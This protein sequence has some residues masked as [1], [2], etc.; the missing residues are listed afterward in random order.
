MWQI[1]DIFNCETIWIACKVTITTGHGNFHKV[2]KKY[3]VAGYL[4]FIQ[5]YF[6]NTLW[7]LIYPPITYYNYSDI[8]F[9]KNH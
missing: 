1:A 5:W 6:P 2:C 9:I 8:C 4:D 3:I 7:H